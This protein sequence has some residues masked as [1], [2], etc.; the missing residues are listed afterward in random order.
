MSS[1]TPNSSYPFDQL[2]PEEKT[3]GWQLEVSH[4]DR[5]ITKNE[6]DIEALKSQVTELRTRVGNSEE[7]LVAQ[8][9]GLAK[10][11]E[12]I[13]SE[14]G[15]M[16]KHMYIAIGGGYVLLFLAEKLLKF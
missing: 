3:V 9:R 7:G 14:I 11:M 2:N 8:V 5:R 4:L 15:D 12:V 1:T 16:K 10:Q 13:A 6:V